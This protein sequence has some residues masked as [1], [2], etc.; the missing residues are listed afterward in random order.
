LYPRL[1]P[2][3]STFQRSMPA[4]HE[5]ADIN[6]LSQGKQDVIS[7]YKVFLIEF[8]EDIRE[9]KD[10]HGFKKVQVYL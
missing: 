2:S 1:M 4:L 6:Q 8:L 5:I 3:G 9:T 7:E 10:A